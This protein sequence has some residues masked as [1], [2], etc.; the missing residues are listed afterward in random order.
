MAV[1]GN[2]MRKLPPRIGRSSLLDQAVM[3]L[4]AV[5][6]GNQN[7]DEKVQQYGSR[8]YAETVQKLRNTINNAKHPDEDMLFATVALQM[9]EVRYPFPPGGEQRN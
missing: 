1:R 7:A 2:F 8:T 5:F 3:G 4:C 6:V 9:Y